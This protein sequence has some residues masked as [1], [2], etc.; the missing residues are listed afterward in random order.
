VTAGFVASA[1]VRDYPDLVSATS[2]G[3]ALPVHRAQP[4]E[5]VVGSSD[6]YLDLGPNIK[7][8]Y[9][10]LATKKSLQST[11]IP[12]N[13]IPIEIKE[14]SV[15]K[16]KAKAPVQNKTSDVSKILSSLGF[17]APKKKVS[18][19]TVIPAKGGRPV[20]A[21]VANSSSQSSGVANVINTLKAEMRQPSLR[22][23]ELPPNSVAAFKE[24]EKQAQMPPPPPPGLSSDSKKLGSWVKIGGTS[25]TIAS[26]QLQASAS[27]GA[28][29][30]VTLSQ[31]DYPT[32]SK[33]SGSAQV[34]R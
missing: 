33:F 18:G 14:V 27:R 24:A 25:E 19:I 21:A 30:G 26:Q 11:A 10:P 2:S 9:K 32:L 13:E 3:S 20:A 29:S 31:N 22:P 23:A 16:T 7:V 28:G 15:K 6:L 17:Q 34:S 8:N 1:G 4:Q 5:G 12:T